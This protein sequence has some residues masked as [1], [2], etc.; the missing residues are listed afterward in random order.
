MRRWL[1]SAPPARSCGS[2]FSLDHVRS[3]YLTDFKSTPI[4]QGNRLVMAIHRQHLTVSRQTFADPCVKYREGLYK[5][6][7]ANISMGERSEIGV[8]VSERSHRK[9]QSVGYD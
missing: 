3:A 5:R 1:L 9:K 7:T 2:F 8:A 6:G 4:N